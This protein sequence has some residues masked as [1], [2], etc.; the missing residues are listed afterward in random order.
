MPE[1]ARRPLDEV[2][3][4]YVSGIHPEKLWHVLEL[5]Q[6][7]SWLCNDLYMSQGVGVSPLEM[8]GYIL[9]YGEAHKN[10]RPAVEPCA[11]C[12]YNSNLYCKCGVAELA[13][14]KVVTM[15]TITTPDGEH[16]TFKYSEGTG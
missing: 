11:S 15:R 16:L 1:N 14:G 4:E 12:E 2:I 5:W 10:V 3:N 13:F 9:A 7:M 8:A 6:E